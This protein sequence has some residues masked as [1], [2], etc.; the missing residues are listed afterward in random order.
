MQDAG[1][2]DELCRLLGDLVPQQDLRERFVEDAL[3]MI[4]ARHDQSLR[5]TEVV[6]P[7]SLAPGQPRP[8]VE[9]VESVTRALAHSMGPVARHFVKR[10]LARAATLDQLRERC[11]ELMENADERERFQKLLADMRHPG[12]LPVS[13]RD[14][15]GD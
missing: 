6:E 3:Q 9:A 2:P 10:A 11:L 14:L 8:A 1:S 4:A 5:P 15:A 7:G 12:S 13:V